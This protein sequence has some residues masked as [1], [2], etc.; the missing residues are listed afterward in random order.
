MVARGTST[1]PFPHLPRSVKSSQSLRGSWMSW[2]AMFSEF[3]DADVNAD[4]F[5]YALTSG[6]NPAASADKL[7]LKTSSAVAASLMSF[8]VRLA[9]NLY[10]VSRILTH[11]DGRQQGGK[12]PT[13]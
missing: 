1:S 3:L 10:K 5:D 11:R 7:F 9:G 13:C 8:T 2:N 6:T 12:L 4:F